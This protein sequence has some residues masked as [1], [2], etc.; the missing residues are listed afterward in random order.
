MIKED[1]MSDNVDL[2]DFPEATAA[3]KK[4]RKI[5]P[6]WIIPIVAALVAIGIAVQKII[7]EG[8]TIEIVFIKAEGIEAGKTFVK[9]KDVEVGHVTK[10][11]LSKDFKQ[12][13]VTAKIEKSAA[14]L[15]VQD[16]KFWIESPRATLSGVSGIGTLLSGNYIGIEPGSATTT[17]NKFTG[18]ETPPPVRGPDSQRPHPPN[19]WRPRRR[20]HSDKT[21]SARIRPDGRGYSSA[22]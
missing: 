14:G 6:V 12:V 8:P 4:K 17:T 19:R 20:R 18:L 9:F 3:P 7:M 21:P 10:V 15:L 2:A 1:N 11:H 5:S 22:D 16:S 13:V